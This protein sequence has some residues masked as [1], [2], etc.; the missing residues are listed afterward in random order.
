M[1]KF[2]VRHL[3]SNLLFIVW[4]LLQRYSRFQASKSK[5]FMPIVSLPK[6][7][8]GLFEA[9]DDNDYTA[10]LVK[11]CINLG[12]IKELQ[13][14]IYES[15]S[16]VDSITFKYDER[17]KSITD[18]DLPLDGIFI[19]HP[20]KNPNEHV[21]RRVYLDVTRARDFIDEYLSRWYVGELFLEDKNVLKAQFQIKKI[22]DFINDLLRDHLPFNLLVL[23]QISWDDVDFVAT[24]LYLEKYFYIELLEIR[25][26][27]N[28]IDALSWEARVNLKD[29]FSQDFS[30]YG[31]NGFSK[32]DVPKEIQIEI[33]NVLNSLLIGKPDPRDLDYINYQEQLDPPMKVASNQIRIEWLHHVLYNNHDVKVDYQV[34][35]NYMRVL[36]LEGLIKAPVVDKSDKKLQDMYVSDPKLFE[37]FWV[38][39][40]K[41]GI[42][43]LLQLTTKNDADTLISISKTDEGLIL[44]DDGKLLRRG[45]DPIFDIP[46]LQKLLLK[47]LFSKDSGYNHQTIELE[48]AVYGGEATKQRQEKFK[49]LVDRVNRNLK[50]HFKIPEAIHYGTNTIRRLV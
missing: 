1:S 44:T 23:Q 19:G 2:P 12:V 42:D 38:S 37:G 5:K 22:T 13:T 24:V 27:R 30:F 31:S 32:V 7:A 17:E 33:L 47:E 41:S 46:P 16:I 35:R 10:Y 11:I 29:K 39:I 14:D 15:D 28:F 20:I 4:D 21:V 45:F 26:A 6:L 40:S 48:E 8:K 18:F 50:E 34:F 43:Y 49:K 3:D 36:W 9:I 25:T